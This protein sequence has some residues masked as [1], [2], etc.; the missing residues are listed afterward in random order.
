[1]AMQ[2][3]TAEFFGAPVSVIDHDNRR[4]LT[5]EE[6]GRCLGY[7]D[8]NASAGIRNLYNRHDDE[9]T[10]EDAR[11]INLM[12][13]DGKPSES[14]IFSATGCQKLGFFANTARA[15]DFRTWAARVLA[16][17]AP[18][19]LPASPLTGEETAR[20]D[21]LD[22]HMAQLAAGMN[23]VLTQL[24]VTRKYIGLLEMNQT[25]KRRVTPEIVRE[26]HALAAEGMNFADIGRLLRISRTAVSLIA[27]DKY[28]ALPAPGDER[29]PQKTVAEMLATY[30]EKKRLDTGGMLSLLTED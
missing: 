19:P 6:A 15:K 28:H 2:P 25:A 9:F 18:I 21:R 8:A 23:T 10:E 13:R 30:L 26:V 7:N 22:A 3:T 27:R 16:G 20:L 4:W 5:A 24:D 1:M 29:P 11:R 14:L 12:R 17:N